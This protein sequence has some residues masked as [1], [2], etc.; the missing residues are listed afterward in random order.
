MGGTA[1]NSDWR[2]P[3]RCLLP[4]LVIGSLATPVAPAW[5]QDYPNKPIRLF[6]GFAA[7]GA[8]DALSRILANGLSKRLGQPIVIEA[9]P[10]AGGN[11]GATA[12][13][14]AEPDGY[15]IGLVTGAHAI[16][17]ALYKSL[18]YDSVD[19]FEM[20]S[21]VVYYALVIDVRSDF[22]AK[23]LKE[24]IALA[25]S[26]PGALSF[27]SVGFGSTHH[28]AGELLD[29]TAGIQMVHVPYRGDSQSITALLGGEVPVVVGTTVLLAPQIE[30]GAVRGLAVT[31]PTRTP[32]LPNVPS[33]DEAGLK[34]FDVRT[35][36]GLLAPKGTP[37][38]II[39]RLN[40]AVRETLADPEI[41]AA[42]E[43][44]T[45]GEVKAS[46]PEE[47]RELIQSQI[48]KWVDVIKTSNIP[49]L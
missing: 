2:I 33:V 4:L 32:L 37:A 6:H 10:G 16:S 47:M 19:G 13:A 40:T 3:I 15:T 9:K 24:L 12:I 26:K 31:S 43:T 46:A 7:G 22:E 39:K 18:A 36:A 49:R 45:G 23:S 5:A 30:S 42:L 44:A 25:K 14:K 11:L 35:W 29:T 48:I 28:L 20:I 17:G 41:K 21:T 8:A 1:R 34:G 27:G 38:G